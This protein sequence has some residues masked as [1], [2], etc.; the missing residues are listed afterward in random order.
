MPILKVMNF[1]KSGTWVTFCHIL[2]I[3][4]FENTNF[5]EQLQATSLSRNKPYF[6]DKIIFLHKTNF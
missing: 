4:N 5:T 6:L 3:H 2:T 1:Q